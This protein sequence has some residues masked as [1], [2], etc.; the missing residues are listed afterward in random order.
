MTST[1]K[2]WSEIED[3]ISR[4]ATTTEKG[5]AFEKFC[6]YYFAVHRKRFQI[7][8]VYFPS[9][10]GRPFPKSIRQ[11]LQ[12]STQDTGV[13]GI[14]VD[15]LGRYTAIQVKFRTDASQLTYRDLATFWADSERADFRL[16]FTN[17]DSVTPVR[18]RRRGH[19]EITRSDLITLSPAVVSGFRIEI[20]SLIESEAN[21][22]KPFPYQEVA[23]S[24]ILKGFENQDRGK[25]IAAC[26]IG[27][28]LISL[29]VHEELKSKT[30][31]FVAPSLYLIRQTIAEWTDQASTKF[32]FI[33]V[34]SDPS[35]V[36]EAGI[37]PLATSFDVP[38][39]TDESQIQKFL[40]AK[41][42]ANK[43]IF[44][45]YQSF[46]VLCAAAAKT[47]SFAPDLM[48]LD[49]SH[50]TAGVNVENGFRLC[51]SDKHLKVRK[52]LFMTATERVFSARL[53]QQLRDEDRQVFSM[54]DVATYGP[55]FH[56]LS[57][58]EA[59]K[60]K[61]ISDYK[62]VVAVLRP[63]DIRDV[64][65]RHS[66]VIDKRESDDPTIRRTEKVVHS[67]LVRRVMHELRVRKMISYHA[68]VRDAKEFASLIEGSK[69]IT[70]DQILGASVDGSMSASLRRSTVS[71]FESSEFGLLSNARCL[72]EGIDVPKIDAVFF[73]SPKQSLV[74]IVQ[75]LGRALRLDRNS[76]EKIAYVVIPVLL[77]S[78]EIN[79]ADSKFDQLFNVIQALRDQDDGVADQ[80][81]QLNLRIA[82]GGGR[83]TPP[84]FI[85]PMLPGILDIEKFEEQLTIRI[86]EVNRNTS[87]QHRSAGALGAGERT[88]AVTRRLKTIADYT[89]E[90]LQES[91]ID[92]TIKRFRSS[93]QVLKRAQIHVNNNNIGHTQRLGLITA[94]SRSN[95]VLTELGDM[96]RRRKVRF[97][98]LFRNQVMIYRDPA[99]SDHAVF[100]YRIFLEFLLRKE[101]LGYWD[102]LFGPYLIDPA[103]S[104]DGEIQLAIER[105]NRVSTIAPNPEIA[106]ERAK[107]EIFEKL[108]ESIDAAITF[109]ELWTDRTTAANQFRYFSRHLSLFGD[110]LEVSG[111]GTRLTLR[112]NENGAGTIRKLLNQSSQFV[113]ADHYGRSLWWSS[114]DS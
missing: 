71:D 108:R 92:P 114:S 88:S 106:G 6:S 18:N 23:L 27:K 107:K 77:E 30:T 41:I 21:K 94:S 74:D 58:S 103:N 50:R 68:T 67:A 104:I 63:S 97:V 37:E 9:V 2:A 15:E 32:N 78:E 54:D 101:S 4:L 49:E 10:D 17:C 60:Q 8:E 56:K 87:G 89:P 66:L 95:F 98:D 12:L 65:E 85:Q 16:V 19:L 11:H 5:K 90:K 22:K 55:R 44:A 83:V 93:G 75:A 36:P 38:T 69:M 29:W 28:T 96:Y 33:A 31:I 80:I 7:S 45:T 13:D 51:L 20:P 57:F 91:L 3:E 43:V 86:A 53:K 24:N 99:F 81:D 109:N 105:C 34:C 62:I 70:G 1:F 52:R 82:T 48:I 84:T 61:I 73:A 100:P 47:S 113:A 59:I 112:I 40:R 39:T 64:I 102:F 110:V 14:F 42:S 79:V 26:G 35:V 46:D 72:T 76:P 25:L 111:G